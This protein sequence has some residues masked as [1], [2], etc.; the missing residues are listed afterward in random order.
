MSESKDADRTPRKLD[1]W[2]TGS[3]PEFLKSYEQRSLSAETADRFRSVRDKILRVAGESMAG[4]RLRVVDIG[5]GAGAQSLLWTQLGHQYLGI[6]INE[7]LIVVARQRASE[8]GS[9]AQFEVGSATSLPCVND[10]ADICLMPELLEHVVDW[11]SCVDEAIRVLRPGGF[12]YISTSNWLC[13]RQ[14]E[15]NL[16]LY[17]WYPGWLKRHFERRALTDRPDL[18]NFAKYPAVHWFSYYQLRGYLNAR[19]LGCQDR[20]DL[21]DVRR[22]GSLARAVLAILRTLPPM[23]LLGHVCTPYTV[24]VA[25]KPGGEA[26]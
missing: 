5:C 26:A 13:P 6:D 9:D 15:F 17:S 12:L 16:P 4:R 3:H 10:S 11:A 22:R 18:A 19:G 7:P 24:V 25:N 2:D 21:V 20:F 8:S 14:Q 23:R 1:A